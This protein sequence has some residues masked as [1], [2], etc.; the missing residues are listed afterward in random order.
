MKNYDK[1]SDSL[2]DEF[3]AEAKRLNSKENYY[4][5]LVGLAK[6]AFPN[7]ELDKSVRIVASWLYDSNKV[8]DVLNDLSRRLAFGKGPLDPHLREIYKKEAINFGKGPLDEYNEL[9]MHDNLKI[10]KTFLEIWAFRESTK[11]KYSDPEKTWNKTLDNVA[12][13][14]RYHT[15]DNKSKKATKKKR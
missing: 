13:L 10:S 7:Q 12:N 4:T 15:K 9:T 14:I 5:D 8:K 11:N 6:R 3:I 1:I 2:I